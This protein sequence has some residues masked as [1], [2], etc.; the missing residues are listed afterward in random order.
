MRPLGP[1]SGL[2]AV[3]TAVAFGF[4]HSDQQF[5]VVMRIV[6]KGIGYLVEKGWQIYCN[7]FVG[8]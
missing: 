6:V 1:A 5:W 7:Q 2:V 4:D 8:L 3:P